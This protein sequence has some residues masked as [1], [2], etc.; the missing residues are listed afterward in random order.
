[1]NENVESSSEFKYIDDYED[2]IDIANLN[3]FS[4]VS[5]GQE[6][7]KRALQGLKGYT[8]GLRTFDSLDD[9]TYGLRKEMQMV[10]FGETKSGKSTILQNIIFNALE[11]NAN[12]PVDEQYKIFINWF[13]L[14]MTGASLF[15]RLVSRYLYLRYNINMSYSDLEG[16]TEKRLSEEQIL[17]YYNEAIIYVSNLATINIIDIPRSAKEITSYLREFH[18]AD[19]RGKIVNGRYESPDNYMFINIVDHMKLIKDNGEKDEFKRAEALSQEL[20][21]SRNFYRDCN[22]ILSQTNT[23]SS[24]EENR[25]NDFVPQRDHLY[26]GKGIVMDADLVLSIGAPYLHKLPKFPSKGK[27]E[28]KYNIVKLRNRYRCLN[29]V[30]SR[31]CDVGARISLDSN[32]AVSTVTELPPA[33]EVDYSLYV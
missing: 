21:M 14:E 4:L 23:K 7:M 2:P 15:Q 19:G 12:K 11:D 29:V 18:L 5:H 13:S 30:A 26:G 25:Q 31:Y 9:I 20:Y 8:K 32:F 17:K 6:A 10:I 3:P 28:D 27:E 24:E 16:F 22:I 33:N 1:M